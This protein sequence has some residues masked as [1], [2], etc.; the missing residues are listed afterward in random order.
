VNFLRVGF[1]IA[2]FGLALLSIA[3]NHHRL[4]WAA[5][6]MLLVSVFARLTLRKRTDSSSPKAGS[7]RSSAM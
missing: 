6:A 1:A 2:G 3:W 7:D 4:G 5:I